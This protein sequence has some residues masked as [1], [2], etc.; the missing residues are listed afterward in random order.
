MRYRRQDLRHGRRLPEGMEAGWVRGEGK[1]RAYCC[2]CTWPVKSE[3][4]AHY[5]GKCGEVASFL[6][7]LQRK[8]EGEAKDARV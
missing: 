8:R 7:V 4:A 6:C 3:E 2:N 5:R 1:N